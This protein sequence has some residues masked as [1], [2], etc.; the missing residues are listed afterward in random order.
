MGRSCTV[1]NINIMRKWIVYVSGWSKND[2]LTSSTIA[3][4]IVALQELFPESK[5]LVITAERQD[6]KLLRSG[7][8]LW[9]LGLKLSKLSDVGVMSKIFGELVYIVRLALI[10]NMLR[11]AIL[12]GRGAQAGGRVGMIAKAMQC[13]FVVESYEPHR[14]Y[15]V[16]SGVWR[17]W[18]LSAK[19]QGLYEWI[20][21]NAEYIFVVS[22]N[23]LREVGKNIPKETILRA[24]P[25][26]V[27][28]DKFKPNERIRKE[29]RG[30]LGFTEETRCGVYVGKFGGIYYELR[31]AA[32]QIREAFQNISSLRIIIVSSS[33]SPSEIMLVN[34]I[35]GQEYSPAITWIG[36]LHTNVSEI[37]AAAD[38]AF[39]FIKPGQSKKYCSPVKIGEYWACGLPVI[40]DEQIGD[41]SDIIRSNNI[42]V[43]KSNSSGISWSL[44]VEL[45]EST[46]TRGEIRNVAERYRSRSLIKNAYGTIELKR[47]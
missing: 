31:D 12:I 8:L 11:P 25:C 6:H 38:F 47:L 9:G 21:L 24:V 26:T 35:V 37:L 20:C 41:D 32:D 29:V 16:E 3:P 19:L 28:V 46:E 18:S 34:N 39:T 17:T 15:M 45:I 7:R 43:V 27:D 40:I 36:A 14:S 42:G 10:I 13:P 1:K 4:S 22:E 2:F 44:L 33:V 30:T 5:I 23:Y